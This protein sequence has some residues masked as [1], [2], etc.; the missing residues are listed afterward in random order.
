MTSFF[1]QRHRRFKFVHRFVFLYCIIKCLSQSIFV[2]KTAYHAV[3]V[4]YWPKMLRF[5]KVTS[6]KPQNRETSICFNSLKILEIV[7]A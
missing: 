1:E 3:L 5:R 2:S 6:G 4:L 7:F